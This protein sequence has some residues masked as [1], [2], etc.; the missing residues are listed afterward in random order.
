M[1]SVHSS[2]IFKL[3][4]A[5]FSFT[6][7]GNFSDFKHSVPAS[8]CCWLPVYTFSC[9]CLY[10]QSGDPLLHKNCIK[11]FIKMLTTAPQ[12]QPYKK[13]QTVVSKDSS[14]QNKYIN[15]YASGKL[16]GTVEKSAMGTINSISLKHSCEQESVRIFM[17]NITFK[18]IYECQ[19]LKAKK[20]SFLKNALY[21]S[22]SCITGIF[23]FLTRI[24]TNEFELRFCS[25]KIYKL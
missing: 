15:Q 11:S 17:D 10:F 3:L 8:I 18:F 7:Y 22:D 16:Y 23:P 13:G 5:S 6:I 19:I 9:I 4:T 12:L 2:S 25:I 14:K 24:N 1:Y 21:V 20:F